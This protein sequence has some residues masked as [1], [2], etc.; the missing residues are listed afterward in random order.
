MA[1][2][3]LGFPGMGEVMAAVLGVRLMCEFPE[4]VQCSGM[5]VVGGP[6]LA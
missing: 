3:R 4:I 6:L 1:G 5:A 2:R